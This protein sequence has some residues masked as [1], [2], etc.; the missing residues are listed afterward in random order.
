MAEQLRLGFIGFGEAGF[1]LARGLRG[2]GLAHLSAYDLNTHTPGLGEKIVQRARESE[3]R[4]CESSGELAAASD[5]LLSTVTADRAAEA[6]GQTAPFLTG[7]HLYADLNS[8]SPTLKQ[9]IGEAI[10]ARGARFVEAAIMSP[11]PPHGHRVPIYLC[12]V[13]APALVELLGPYGMN[14]EVL[15]EQIGAASATKMCRSIIVKGLEALLLECVLGAVPYGADDRVFAT[16]N[17]SFPG[18]DWQRLAGYMIGRVV[19]HGERRAR[20]M[21]E[22]S[23]TLRAIGIEPIMAEAA[24]RRQAWCA[25]LKLLERFGGRVPNDYREVVRAVEEKFAPEQPD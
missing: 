20:E 1:N 2:A 15:S 8:V 12:G 14:L 25:Q 21:E 22:V 5:V 16:L 18:V 9:S 7:R 24:A 17:E 10:A 4:L 19:E 13:H 3:V 23:S 6:A 11:V